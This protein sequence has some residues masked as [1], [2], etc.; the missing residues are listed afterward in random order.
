M[1][2]FATGIVVGLAT[3]LA[4]GRRQKQWAE[5]TDKGKGVRIA[6]IAALCILVIAGIGLFFLLPELPV[7]YWVF[8]ALLSIISVKFD[9]MK[10]QS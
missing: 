8:V 4:S 1:F 6:I 7:N 5:F 2:G 9:I 3:G 10:G